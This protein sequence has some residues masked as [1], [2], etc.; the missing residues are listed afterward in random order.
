MTRFGLSSVFLWCAV[1]AQAQPTREYASHPVA[2]AASSAADAAYR[3]NMG[4]MRS[5]LRNLITAQELYQTGNHAFAG[6]IDQLPT[7]HPMIGAHVDI[8]SAGPDGWAA[9]EKL[10]TGAGIGRSCVIWIGAI[11]SSD[12]PST[13]AEHKTFPEAEVACDGDGLHQRAEWAA[14]AQSYM[15][16]ALRKLAKSEE[17]YLALNGRYTTDATK[18]EPF[19]WDQGVSISIVSATDQGWAA[20][21]SFSQFPGKLCVMWRG[22]LDASGLGRTVDRD[23]VACDQL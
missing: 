2:P 21:A 6:D 11:A 8:V 4:Q 9:V 13:E 16:Y 22:E 19:V 20:K 1:V 18:L 15:T 23:Q 5:D 17:K 12:R 3:A 10:P 7:F 14:A